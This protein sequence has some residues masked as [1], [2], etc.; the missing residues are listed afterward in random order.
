MPL[1]LFDYLLQR[2][3]LVKD[4]WYMVLKHENRYNRSGM[5]L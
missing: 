5:L 1:S 2:F 4:N 3:I